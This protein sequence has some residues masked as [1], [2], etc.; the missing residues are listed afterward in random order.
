[1]IEPLLWRLDEDDENIEKDNEDLSII[2]DINT[3]TSE[4]SAKLCDEVCKIDLGFRRKTSILDILSKK[5][6]S[7]D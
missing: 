2:D 5:T 1:M 7:F 6:I 4:S 3:Q